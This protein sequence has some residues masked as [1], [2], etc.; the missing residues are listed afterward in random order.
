MVLHLARSVQQPS[1]KLYLACEACQVSVPSTAC[2]KPSHRK[3]RLSP[4]VRVG[5]W[6]QRNISETWERCRCV[7]G[8]TNG[9]GALR[10][11]TKRGHGVV[12]VLV[13][14]S[15]GPNR[16]QTSEGGVPKD[17]GKVSVPG[18]PPQQKGQPHRS[19]RRPPQKSKLEVST[20]SMKITQMSKLLFSTY[21]FKQDLATQQGLGRLMVLSR[22]VKTANSSSRW[23]CWNL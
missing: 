19:R 12:L 20:T 8:S 11:N 17:K 3:V 15:N 6:S 1:V 5:L 4:V 18:Q 10:R 16:G 2:C 22:D 7:V 21:L 13:S 14:A 23:P 9:F